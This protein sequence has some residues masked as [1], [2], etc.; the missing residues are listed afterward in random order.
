[1]TELILIR[2]GV[3]AWNREARF[4]GRIDIPLEP[5]GHA[6]AERAAAAIAALAADRAVSALYSSDLT[7]TRQ[8]AE[9]IAR[10][11]GMEARLEPGLRERNYGAFEGLTGAD[12][13]RDWAEAFRRWRDREPDFELPGG[14]ESLRRFHQRVVDTLEALARRH[15]GERVLAVTHGGVLDCAYRHAAGLDLRAARQHDL[16]N[17][18]LNTIALTDTGWRVIDWADVRH[19]EDPPDGPRPWG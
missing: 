18:S 1:M 14:G 8:T 10:R 5:D 11:L 3:T 9:P 19:L 13:Q 16:L 6:D 12:L 7:R 17:T 15:P 2:H 4:Q